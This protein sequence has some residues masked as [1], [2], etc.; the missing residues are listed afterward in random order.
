M[1]TLWAD[2]HFNLASVVINLQI[3]IK[4]LW[5]CIKL[6]KSRCILQINMYICSSFSNAYER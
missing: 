4:R 2:Y 5:F 3:E 6:N 1:L